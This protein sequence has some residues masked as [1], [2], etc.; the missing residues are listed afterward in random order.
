MSKAFLCTDNESPNCYLVQSE[1]SF[2]LSQ[3]AQGLHLI[4]CCL[5]YS[6]YTG[7]AVD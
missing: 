4:T 6:A 5:H 7:L 2:H 3:Q 1:P